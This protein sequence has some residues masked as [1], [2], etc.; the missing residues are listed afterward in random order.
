LAT[1]SPAA[2]RLL[3]FAAD[4]HYEATVA[5]GS[6][7]DAETLKVLINSAEETRVKMV[8]TPEKQVSRFITGA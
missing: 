2:V 6:N 1:I 3:R 4:K 7:W 8:E 5:Q